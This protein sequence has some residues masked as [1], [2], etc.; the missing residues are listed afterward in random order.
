MVPEELR[1][2]VGSAGEV[3]GPEPPY[4][5]VPAKVQAAIEQ[6]MSDSGLTAARLPVDN[7]ANLY[8]Q[9]KVVQKAL[10]AL[11][12]EVKVALYE[13]NQVH[14][15]PVLPR[16]V[17]FSFKRQDALGLTDARSKPGRVLISLSRNLAAD[18]VGLTTLHE[19]GHLIDLLYF[20]PVDV[21]AEAGIPKL[22]VDAV[23]E[24]VK[25]TQVWKHY[26]GRLNV[27]PRDHIATYLAN[28]K[29]VWARAYAQYI[30][31]ESGNENL[32]AAVKEQT[33]THGGTALPEHW[34]TEDF[35]P[36]R[37]AINHLFH[38]KGWLRK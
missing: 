12:N 26:Q 38:T 5:E 11:Q 34:T 36:V 7:D 23:M 20:P 9:F 33:S 21:M 16:Q 1:Q 13:A 6:H 4:F 18:E 29:E 8:Q 37:R 30:A 22:E 24:A 10:P 28:P 19:A 3:F 2:D 14:L 15:L 31:E 35:Q 27:D 32:L 25:E 17:E